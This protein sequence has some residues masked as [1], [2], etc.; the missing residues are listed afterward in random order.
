MSRTKKIPRPQTDVV[1]KHYDGVNNTPA[2]QLIS[3]GWAEMLDNGVIGDELICNWDNKA[4]VAF[5]QDRAVGVI[6]YSP[7]E[8]R[9]SIWITLSYVREEYRRQGIYSQLFAALVT[10]A[11]ELKAVG[12]EGGI[13][14]KNTEMLAASDKMNRKRMYITTRFEVPALTTGEKPT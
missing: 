8:Y 2:I 11:A 10:K 3:N 5:H 9:K 4:I 6:A 13:S 7:I 1:I 12:I 14:I